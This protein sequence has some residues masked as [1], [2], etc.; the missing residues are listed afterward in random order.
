MQPLVET[1]A[2]AQQS[3]CQ[4]GGFR[5]GPRCSSWRLKRIFINKKKHSHKL[6]RGK[7]ITWAAMRD[8]RERT[9]TQTM[10]TCA[11]P[12]CATMS[13]NLQGA[14]QYFLRTFLR[15]NILNTVSEWICVNARKLSF[16]DML[17]EYHLTPEYLPNVQ[18]TTH[19]N[20]K[21]G[22]SVLLSFFLPQ[23]MIGLLLQFIYYTTPNNG[24]CTTAL[25]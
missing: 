15:E 7:A 17:M 19:N 4:D 12:S 6:R 23:Q 3:Q 14:K 25:G 5:A 11:V 8:E 18:T 10:S 20:N 1:N 24:P 21:N 16:L 22:G 2:I 9:I 13:L